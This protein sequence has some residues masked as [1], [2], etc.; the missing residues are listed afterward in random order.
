MFDLV[1]TEKPKRVP[2]TEDGYARLFRGIKPTFN[3]NLVDGD[4]DNYRAAM[5][6]KVILFISKQKNGVATTKEISNHCDRAPESM[7]VYIS[8]MIRARLI[9]RTR[10]GNNVWSHNLTQRSKMA[11][12]AAERR[13]A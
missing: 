6:A 2:Y 5:R 9:E 12:E 8:G 11:I 1:T 13:A 10:D 7:R 4:K 3:T